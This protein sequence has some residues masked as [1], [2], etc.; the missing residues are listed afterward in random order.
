MPRRA[1]GEPRCQLASRIR[2]S[3]PAR[4]QLGA[5]A[6]ELPP[7]LSSRT[8][9][10][11]W[12]P[13]SASEVEFTRL[14]VLLRGKN[15]LFNLLYLLSKTCAEKRRRHRERQRVAD[16][17]VNGEGCGTTD[18]GTTD[19]EEIVGDGGTTYGGNMAD[20]RENGDC[21]AVLACQ[22]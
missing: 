22:L 9:F 14:T 7:A 11:S 18:G 13:L 4:L 6:L 20:G 17:E 15:F 21:G 8:G 2:C 16:G 1:N 19:G 5:H 12:F 3:S 10:I